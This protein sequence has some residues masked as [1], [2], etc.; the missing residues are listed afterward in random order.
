LS[1]QE[2]KGNGCFTDFD[3][4]LKARLAR[5]IPSRS[6]QLGAEGRFSGISARYDCRIKI[7]YHQDVMRLL[8]EGMLVA[9]RNF[10]SRPDLERFTL[11][12]IS[13]IMPEHFG[14]RGLTDQSYYPMQFEI[15]E[16]AVPD[17][18]TD[19]RS[20]MIVQ[21]SAIPVN[22]DLVLAPEGPSFERGFSF[23]VLGE[24][25]LVLSSAIIDKMYNESVLETLDW[26]SGAGDPWSSP[27]I[28]TIKMFS[29]QDR[30]P[31]PI[32][33][34]LE[35]LVRYHFGVFAFTG[36]GKS[37]LLANI[38]RRVLLHLPESRIVIFDISSEYPFLLADILA[39]E[40]IPSLLVMESEP[41]DPEELF[42]SVVKPRVFEEEARALPLF[43]R[44]FDLGR[45]GTYVE[46]PEYE[47]PTYGGM[48][49]ELSNIGGSVDS[50]AGQA[51]QEIRLRI[52]T[53]MTEIGASDGDVPDD[54]SA[55]S[56]GEDAEMVLEERGLRRGSSLH[57]W[58]AATKRLPQ[59]VRMASEHEWSPKGSEYTLE[60]ICSAMDGGTRLVCLSISEPDAI[61]R[62]A[63]EVTSETLR[64]RKSQFRVKPYIL[65]V[66]DEAQEFIPHQSTAGLEGTCS[67]N[68]ERILRQGRKYGL[69]TCISTQ[70]IAYLNTN[71]LQQLHTY[72][73]GT[74]PRPYD[75]TVVSDVFAVDL[76]ILE[77][78]LE[79]APGDWLLSSYTATGIRNVPIFIHADDAEEALR[80]AMGEASP[81]GKA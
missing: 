37:N 75:R 43:R 24:E 4:R 10:K 29:S 6:P 7:E 13:R 1:T 3:G 50:P 25:A 44:M 52:L 9:V 41:A 39:D 26:T 59:L 32:Y 73:V 61:R 78:T 42:N 53:R 47:M 55:V 64:R 31:I 71:A 2:G 34:D 36:G 56:I 77:K 30:D 69:G 40:K 33:L 19:D 57:N 81:E 14:L 72:F 70:R 5:V 80:G 22:Y 49:S 51:A 60:R 67:K 45:V 16:E 11:L 21:A 66:F 18:Q 15:I 23:P 65:F 38:L 35:S 48:L 74:L 27:R 8:E 54:S 79:F 46:P 76:G 28:G 17:W 12:E 68:I 20:A 58:A 63:I 62:L